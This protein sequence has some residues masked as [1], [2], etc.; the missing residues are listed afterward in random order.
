MLYRGM[1]A[2]LTSVSGQ[3]NKEDCVDTSMPELDASTLRL[4]ETKRARELLSSRLF[5][6]FQIL[7]DVMFLFSLNMIVIDVMRT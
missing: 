3:N 2:L 7:G 5:F 6:F 4:E 1:V